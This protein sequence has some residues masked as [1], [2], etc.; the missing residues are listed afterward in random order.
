MSL[1]ASAAISVFVSCFLVASC[2]KEDKGK[3]PAD[4]DPAP[5]K[6]AAPEPQEP[7]EAA[8]PASD[9]ALAAGAVKLEEAAEALVGAIVTKE[10]DERTGSWI[11]PSHPVEIRTV[12][13]AC[14]GPADECASSSKVAGPD[15]FEEE[16]E[17]WFPLEARVDSCDETCCTLVT[18]TEEAGDMHSRLDKLCFG[19]DG[20]GG[21]YLQALHR[22][23][24]P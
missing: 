19:K 7:Q 12:S 22:T 8:A 3:K 10:L 13:G 14:D 20:S 23:E 21:L 2:S 9:S 4:Q 5:E 6:I 1:R 16:I 17:E 11:H 18:N 24:G 15:A